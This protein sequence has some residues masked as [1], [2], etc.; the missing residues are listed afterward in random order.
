M[1]VIFTTLLR[2]FPSIELA[3]DEPEYKRGLSVRGPVALRIA[4]KQA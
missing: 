2:R 4:V 3:G 1:E